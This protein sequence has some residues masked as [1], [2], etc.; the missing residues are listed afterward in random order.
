MITRWRTDVELV[1]DR[2]HER[3]EGQ[4][5]EKGPVLGMVQDVDEL[6]RVQPGIHGVHHGAHARHAVVQLEMPV[7]V[8][9]DGGHRIAFA[10][11]EVLED[12]RQ[13]L[14]PLAGGRP[15]VS[16]DRAL[17]GARDE[18]HRGEHLGRVLQQG[19]DEEGLVHH[20]PTHG[21]PPEQGTWRA[22]AILRWSREPPEGAGHAEIS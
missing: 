20:E 1:P 8:P 10:E 5:H 7:G 6:A 15:G 13:L 14:G 17:D 22:E 21:R 3:H 12:L 11:R 19:G 4:V 9:R 2:L 16:V 18:G